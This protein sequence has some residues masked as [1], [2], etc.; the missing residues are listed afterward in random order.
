M[1]FAEMASRITGS[2]PPAGG[3]GGE[4]NAVYRINRDGF[5]SEVFR[6]PVMILSLGEAGGKV[7]AATGNEGRIYEIVPADEVVTNIARVRSSQA[8]SLL[9]LDD[10]SLLVGTANPAA[11]VRVGAGF[12]QKGTFVS[13]PLDAEQI[14]RF[15]RARWRSKLPDGTRLT[16]ATRS[17]N[18][19]DPDDPAWDAW[20]AETDASAGAQVA[21][22]SARFL[23][24]RLTFETKDSTRSPVL[25]EIEIPRVA[26]NQPPK[27]TTLRVGP[28]VKLAQD[29]AMMAIKAKL[30]AFGAQQQEGP[31]ARQNVFAIFWKA[32]DPNGD[33]M[34]YNIYYRQVGRER[35]VRLEED[36][37]ETLKL[38]DTRTV[39]DGWYE[40]RL[41]AGDRP[42]NPPGTDLSYAR[43][44]EAVLVDNTPPAIRV[45]RLQPDGKKLRVRAVATDALSPIAAAR[46]VVDSNDEWIALL[47]ADDMFD[48]QEET[49]EFVVEGLEDGEHVI[50]IY[51]TDVSGNAAFVSQAFTIGP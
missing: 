17:G 37:K 35:W 1:S 19:K 11:V 18:V 43:V 32:E 44:G 12:A 42:D 47:P 20:S 5:V 4:G 39:A 33:D 9:R 22:P 51:A 34:L 21:S 50:A 10:G 13:A 40:V 26:E 36:F 27:I 8:V 46:Y 23:Q 48:A 15:G 7:Y 31:D 24:Y 49:L 3:S 41:V 45:D 38:W 2:R 30:G 28:A 25:S 29:P 16:L 6:E 14:A